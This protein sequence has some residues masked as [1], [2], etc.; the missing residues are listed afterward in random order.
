MF[1]L[2]GLGE[3]LY[4]KEEG[5]RGRGKAKIGIATKHHKFSLFGNSSD[6]FD[7]FLII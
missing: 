3:S 6:Y 4:Y 5:E 2:N 7:L 1:S